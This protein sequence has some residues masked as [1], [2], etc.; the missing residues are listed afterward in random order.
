M[1]PGL[2]IGTQNSARAGCRILKQGPINLLHS[3]NAPLVALFCQSQSTVQAINFG[4]HSPAERWREL[5]SLQPG[6][7]PNHT[8]PAIGQGRS[9]QRWAPW[10]ELFPACGL[11]VNFVG[12]VSTDGGSFLARQAASW[13]PLRG[14][15]FAFFFRSGRS[16]LIGLRAG[17]GPE[18]T[19]KKN[20]PHHWSG[21][22]IAP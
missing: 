2:E 10:Y 14:D 18:E 16:T 9:L 20:A 12:R 6:P 11:C 22:E 21:A 13:T 4:S 5:I 1:G 8:Y 17:G 7:W 3:K 19:N 15:L